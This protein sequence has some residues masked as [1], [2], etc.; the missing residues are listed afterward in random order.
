[1]YQSESDSML[2][3]QGPAY[4]MVYE[5]MELRVRYS[6]RSRTVLNVELVLVLH[7]WFGA[8]V[9]GYNPGLTL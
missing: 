4:E 3:A 8:H 6:G 2:C 7:C 5:D 9:L 1:M